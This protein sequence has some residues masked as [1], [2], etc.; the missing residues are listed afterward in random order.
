MKFRAHK[1]L[2]AHGAGPKEEVETL[3]AFEAKTHLARIL[4]EASAGKRFVVTHRGR[5]VAEIHP[6]GASRRR[7]KWGDMKDAVRMSEDFC[8]PLPSLEEFFR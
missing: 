8:E 1:H 3:G 2:A 5:A 6:P 4:R 7:P